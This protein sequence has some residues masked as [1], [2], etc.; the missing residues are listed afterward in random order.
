M[1]RFPEPRP[2]FT[3]ELEVRDYELD[4][5]GVVN[6]AVY[7]NYL[8][9]ARHEYLHTRGISLDDLWSRGFSPVVTKIDLAFLH[10]LR[11]R[12]RFLVT[13][14][15]EAVTRVRFTFVQ[16]LKPL[17]WPRPFAWARVTGTVLNASGRPEI[18]PD[19]RRL[20]DDIELTQLSST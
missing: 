19:F 13:L 12:D 3:L 11:S 17:S 15:V 7:Q 8:E 10:S 5:F 6:N 1:P 14:A 20:Q 16:T 18:P 9:H 4:R 2:C